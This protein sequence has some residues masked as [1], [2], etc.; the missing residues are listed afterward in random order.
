VSGPRPEAGEGG[1][2]EP[3]E[4][5]AAA[6]DPAVRLDDLEA[7]LPHLTD[8]DLLALA[9]YASGADRADRDAARAQVDAAAR[10]AGRGAGLDAALDKLRGWAM[11]NPYAAA[12]V[13]GVTDGTSRLAL[14]M[15]ALPGLFDAVTGLAAGDGADPVDVALLTE[16]W[17]ELE[18][19]GEGLGDEAD[20][21]VAEALEAAHADR[22]DGARL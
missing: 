1:P 16:P 10:A 18:A 2:N 22:E 12:G 13:L 8:G 6:A 20:V 7:L 15:N 9:A 14:R 5:G 3:A 19:P 17:E 21:D 11:K 4:G